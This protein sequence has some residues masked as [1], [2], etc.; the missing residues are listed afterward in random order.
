MTEMYQYCTREEE[1]RLDQ[2]RNQYQKEELH[3][4][5]NLIQTL[6]HTLV[7]VKA[8]VSSLIKT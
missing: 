4:L 3:I 5:S 6:S 7:K 2:R 1:M 8:K